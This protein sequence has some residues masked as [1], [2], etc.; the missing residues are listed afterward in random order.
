MDPFI[1]LGRAVADAFG[2]SFYHFDTY[3][4]M[5]CGMCFVRMYNIYGRRLIVVSI[6]KE[7]I[8]PEYDTCIAIMWRIMRR[9]NDHVSVIKSLPLPICEE[10]LEHISLPINIVYEEFDKR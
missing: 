9:I 4:A 2:G 5:T 1:L 6:N 10:L 3:S 8:E 7:V